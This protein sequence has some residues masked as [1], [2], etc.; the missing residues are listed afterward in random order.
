MPAVTDDLLKA[1]EAS[2]SARASS[3]LK[4]ILEKGVD[5]WE[6]HL[7]LF[8]AVQRVLNPPF[9]NPHLP[10]MYRIH[11]DFIPYLAKEDIPPLVHLEVMEYAKRPK[12]EK[13]PKGKPLTSPV[14]F[15][16]VESA[17]HKRDMEKTALL[18]T[19]FSSQKGGK[20]LARRLLLLGS[21]YLD[22]SLGHSISCT[23][24]I[25]LEMIERQ[26]QDPWPVLA[27]LADYFCKGSFHTTPGLRKLTPFAS[28]DAIKHHLVRATSGT[29]IVNLH[30]TITVYTMERVRHFF[31]KEEYD[32]LVAAWTAFMGKKR[33]EEFKWDLPDV[34]PADNYPKFY[35]S[36]SRLE[37]KPVIAL[38][39][40]MISSEQ[41]RRQAGRF[42]IKGVGDLYQGN[43]NP[44]Y[45][46][47]LGSA[48]WVVEK[49]WNQNSIV[50]NALF[51]F[52]DFFFKG[53]KS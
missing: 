13:L 2:D 46:T 6:I 22:D 43:Y 53:I 7:S 41:G 52:L 10:K 49:Y 26:D 4:E 48:L 34:K 11:R 27:T 21:G 42:L 25:L 38:V 18:M 33:G 37:T 40:G 24:P 15:E 9:I 30:H 32:H 23:A 45:V 12:L 51:Q 19:T 31:N 8:P 1:I 35:E 47:G 39:K 20:E 36:F 44:H 3:Q 5:V 50:L 16:D 17:I 29:G 14:S 28:E